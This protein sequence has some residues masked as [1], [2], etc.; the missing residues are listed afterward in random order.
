MSFPSRIRG[1]RLS[2]CRKG[3]LYQSSTSENESVVIWAHK[4][5]EDQTV[6]RVRRITG[7]AESR[8][9]RW[10][11]GIPKS[12]TNSDDQKKQFCMLAHFIS[13]ISITVFF[14]IQRSFWT[15][16]VF[17]SPIVSRSLVPLV[18]SIYEYLFLPTLSTDFLITACCS[19]LQGVAICSSYQKKRTERTL[20]GRE[21]KEENKLA[22][23]DEP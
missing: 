6:R 9:N 21:E 13:W 15:V 12:Y 11:W 19:S 2:S 22:K 20:L 8:R 17:P 4:I 5:V 10:K 18:P 14:S 23:R 3:N 7:D 16:Y 1:C